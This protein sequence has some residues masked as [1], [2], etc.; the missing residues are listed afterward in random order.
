MTTCSNQIRVL[1]LVNAITFDA[2]QLEAADITDDGNVTISDAMH[3]AQWLVDPN[4]TL[5]VLFKP[6]WELANDSHM[7]QPQP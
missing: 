3:I 7:L 6:L 5:G 2:D 4:G 1:D